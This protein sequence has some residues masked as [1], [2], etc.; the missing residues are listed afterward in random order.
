MKA[1]AFRPCIKQSP[2]RGCP[3]EGSKVTLGKVFSPEQ[4]SA[5]DLA[6]SSQSLA[7]RVERGTSV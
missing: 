7:W 6:E 2:S 1:Q 4:V 3:W 5:K